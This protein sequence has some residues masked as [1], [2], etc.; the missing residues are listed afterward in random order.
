[1]ERVEEGTTARATVFPRRGLGD[2][3]ALLTFSQVTSLTD[4]L[5]KVPTFEYDAQGNLTAIGGSFARRERTSMKLWL[6]RPRAERHGHLHRDYRAGR[7][8]RK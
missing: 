8:L 5:G 3:V 1:M 4:P 7:W 6:P 2:D